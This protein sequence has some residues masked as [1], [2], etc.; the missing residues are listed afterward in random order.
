MPRITS[1]GETPIIDVHASREHGHP[2]CHVGPRGITVY[3]FTN[4]IS[5]TA[6]LSSRDLRFIYSYYNE[7]IRC[8]N[9]LNWPVVA[10]PPDH[11]NTL[12]HP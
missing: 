1:P 2:H 6:P 12:F 7:L 11:R 5:P 9:G 3:V 8:F 4:G 10:C